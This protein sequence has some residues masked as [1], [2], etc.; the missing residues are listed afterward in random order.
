MP[1]S[2]PQAQIPGC[3]TRPHPWP[4]QS[5]PL[6]PSF[7]PTTDIL[8]AHPTPRIPCCQLPASASKQDAFH[9]LHGSLPILH[10]SPKHLLYPRAA[11]HPCSRFDPWVRSILWRRKW[12]SI[13]VFLPE[14]SHVQRSLVGYSSWGCRVRPDMTEPLFPLFPHLFAMK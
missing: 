8:P 5:A 1:P 10:H 14:K 13:P 7:S 12:Q 9:P 2:H 3:H 4:W 11:G 6:V